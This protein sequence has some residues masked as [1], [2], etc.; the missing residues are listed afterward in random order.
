MGGVA[1]KA[2]QLAQ[3]QALSGDKVARR[4]AFPYN[5]GALRPAYAGLANRA[6]EPFKVVVLGDSITDGANAL[7]YGTRWVD[8]LRDRLRMDYPTPGF[9]GG[10]GYLPAFSSGVGKPAQPYSQIIGTTP[11]TDSNFGLGLKTALVTSARG[12][13]YAIT[14]TSFDVYYATGPSTG[15]LSITIDGGTPVTVTTTGALGH[16]VWK[17]PALTAGQ[18]V[19]RVLGATTTSAYFSGVFVYN[20]DETAGIHVYEGGR[21]GYRASQFA[22]TAVTNSYDMLRL[23]LP[24][25]VVVALGTN[26]FSQQVAIDAYKASMRTIFGRIRGKAPNAAILLTAYSRRGDVAAGQAIEWQD[27]VSALYDLADEDIGGLNGASGIAAADLTRWM[28]EAALTGADLFGIYDIDRVHP[29]PKG[30]ALIGET[31]A[32]ALRIG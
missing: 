10:F 19:V 23:I 11:G 3:A 25:L 30:H 13:E 27:Y 29:L 18:H 21:F 14:G 1:A 24:H 28:P 6:V 4:R 20:G 2:L 16:G 17:S 15:S 22:A 12:Y 9:V 26:D 32:R 7:T 5:P 8:R 31:M